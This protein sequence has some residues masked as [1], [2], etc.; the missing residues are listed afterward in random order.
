MA[1]L[2]KLFH[3]EMTEQTQKGVIRETD[4]HVVKYFNTFFEDVAYLKELKHYFDEKIYICLY[5]YFYDPLDDIQESEL[6]ALVKRRHQDDDDISHHITSQAE[7][8]GDGIS[9]TVSERL[10]EEEIVVDFLSSKGRLSQA[11]RKMF[12]LNQKWDDIMNESVPHMECYDPDSKHEVVVFTDYLKYEAVLRLVPDIFV[13]AFKSIELAKLWWTHANQVYTSKPIERRTVKEFAK[14]E[15][16]LEMQIIRVTEDIQRYE[17]AVKSQEKELESLNKREQRFQLLSEQC[18][19]LEDRK[20]YVSQSYY[21][22]LNN[23]QSMKEELGLLE[24]GTKRYREIEVM[25]EESDKKL[26]LTQDELKVLAYHFHIVQEDFNLEMELRPHL[27]RFSA[28]IEVKMTDL[29]KDI[30]DKSKEQRKTEKRLVLLKTNCDRMRQIMH[31]LHSKNEDEKED[32]MDEVEV[33]KERT[34]TDVEG[35]KKDTKKDSNATTGTKLPQPPA[36]HRMP[37]YQLET[38]NRAQHRKVKVK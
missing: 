16:H 11:V 4:K 21:T 38:A 37:K 3:Q 2:K 20:D 24:K 9:D 35:K 25:L 5:E 23:I 32:T 26:T 33:E 8:N 19:K 15:G 7:I 14:Q 18:E 36:R 6:E 17:E 34:K 10:E 1:H 30:A 31:K 29:K 28:D 12:K 22:L 27:I 13:K